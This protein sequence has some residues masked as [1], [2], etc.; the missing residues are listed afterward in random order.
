[1]NPQE[2]QAFTDALQRNLERDP[3]VLG[4]MAAGSM[5]DTSHPPDQWSD[6]DF[7]LVVEPEAVT[8]FRTHSEWLPDSET[9]VMYFK[10]TQH[11]G[12]KAIYGSGHLLEFA[13]SDREGIVRAR[14]NDYRLLIDRAGLA[15]D[16]ARIQRET[17]A[18]AT[19]FAGDDVSLIGQYLTN[20]LVGV[21]RYRRGEIMSGRQLITVSSLHAL[22][23]LI[24]K[25]FPVE[26][27]AALDNLDPLRRIELAY[28]TL[29]AQINAILR[30]EPDRA[31]LALLDFTDALFRDRV[32]G[33]PAEAVATVRRS[34]EPISA[35]G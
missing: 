32:A 8:W 4:L 14:V 11:D 1:M 16:L 26:T 3:R 24:P 6:H 5:A 19:V 23:R 34:I 17:E 12:L 29:G 2:Y 7:W 25:H 20:L 9:L 18:E 33:Y 13:V 21:W 22:L 15:A 27:P 35:Q 10:E 30:L 28:P 31:A